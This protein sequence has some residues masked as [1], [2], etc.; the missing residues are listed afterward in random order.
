MMD[1]DSA[2]LGRARQDIQSL[3]SRGLEL[4][5]HGNA[6]GLLAGARLVKFKH[7]AHCEAGCTASARAKSMCIR[8]DQDRIVDQHA[9]HSLNS[10]TC[11]LP[12]TT[13]PF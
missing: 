10:K 2:T 5:E 12:E 9:P 8:D 6:H 3:A 11:K 1:N 4:P 7:S 13:Q